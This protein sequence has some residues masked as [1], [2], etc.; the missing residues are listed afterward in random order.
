MRD[1]PALFTDPPL[2]TAD[3]YNLAAALFLL[4]DPA[5]LQL[6]SALATFPGG[7]ARPVDLIP[8][9]GR[10]RQPTVSHHLNLLAGAGLVTRRRQGVGVFYRLQL[11]EVARVLA[12]LQPNWVA[13]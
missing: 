7:E 12:A 6:L 4:A 1:L 5:R 8:I 2:S 10:L 9:L 13:S 3:A 11:R